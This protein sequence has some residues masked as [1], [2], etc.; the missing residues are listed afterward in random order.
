LLSLDPL[1]ENVHRTLMRLYAARGRHDAALAQYERCRRELSDQLG[2]Q[3]ESQTEALANAIRAARRERPA[4][5][6]IRSPPDRQQPDPG[7]SRTPSDRP[8]IAVLPF[9]NLSGDAGQQYFIDA[10]TE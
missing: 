3:P 4:R 1:Q 7:E 8:S 5:L 10:I 2:V 9:D 6:Q